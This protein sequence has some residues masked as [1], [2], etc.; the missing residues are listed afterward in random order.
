MLNR[1]KSGKSLILLTIVICVMSLA[2]V[3]VA[4]IFNNNGKD[5]TAEEAFKLNVYQYYLEIENYKAEKSS[6]ENSQF[7][8]N[9]LYAYGV[10]MKAVIPDIVET[11][12]SK[13]KIE[14]GKLVYIGIDEKEA[15][16]TNEV[17]I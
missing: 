14:K 6:D 15:K 1:D 9:E 12:M 2:I 7:D 13:F 3:F 11:D 4:R 8:V 5:K 16:W 10:D 17:R